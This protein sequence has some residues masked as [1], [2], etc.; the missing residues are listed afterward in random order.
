[1]VKQL[2]SIG[3]TS[4]EQLRNADLEAYYARVQECY[5]HHGKGKPFDLT[6]K[7]ARGLIEAARRLPTVVE[8]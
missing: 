7:T 8:E 1:M 3:Y 5:R 2:W 6:S 4:L